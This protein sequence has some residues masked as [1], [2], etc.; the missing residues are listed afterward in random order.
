M[1]DAAVRADRRWDSLLGPKISAASFRDEAVA[2]EV[3]GAMLALWSVFG[4]SSPLELHRP[5]PVPAGFLHERLDSPEALR[6]WIT[7]SGKHPLRIDYKPG[8][9]VLR[10]ADGSAGCVVTLAVYWAMTGPAAS[11][12]RWH[13]ERVDKAVAV[14]RA[15]R[16]SGARSS[17]W[18]A[19]RKKLKGK[20]S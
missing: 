15:E 14:R 16:V 2:A 18:A 10:P 3:R 19:A 9:V 6:E 17:R 12:S 1:R 13:Q 7:V 5:W 11:L 4:P 20:W 8:H